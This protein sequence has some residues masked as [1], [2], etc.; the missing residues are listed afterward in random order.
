MGG[1]KNPSL[2][3]HIGVYMI[4]QPIQDEELSTFLKNLP[5][6]HRTTYLL[7]DK[8]V[9]LTGVAATTMVNKMR[10]NHH[11]GFLEAY[12]LAQAYIAGALLSSTIKG[13]DKI[14]RAHV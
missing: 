3:L 2:L 12:I 14:G 11:L 10:A 7:Q 4:S 8:N 5:D 9:R 13:N 1:S 6:D